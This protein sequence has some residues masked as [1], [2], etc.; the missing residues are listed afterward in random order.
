MNRGAPGWA[1][2]GLLQRGHQR[3]R[4]EPA[5]GSGSGALAR[6]AALLAG[7][8]RNQL[9]RGLELAAGAW[10]PFWPGWNNGLLQ[11]SHQCLRE[12][13]PGQQALGLLQKPRSCKQIEGAGDTLKRHPYSGDVSLCTAAIAASGRTRSWQKAIA[14][15]DELRGSGAQG[16]VITFNAR[17]SA[18]EKGQQWQRALGFLQDMRQAGLQPNVITFRALISA[19]KRVSRGSVRSVSCRVRG[20]PGCSQT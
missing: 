5:V 12:E 4:E 14:L 7:A 18:C 2:R 1:E 16:D 11:R 19:C 20:R 17:T 8:G 6:V 9:P 3:L 10:A 15:W 13:P